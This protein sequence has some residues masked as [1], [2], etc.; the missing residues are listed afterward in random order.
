MGVQDDHDCN[1][2]H[3]VDLEMWKYGLRVMSWQGK[4]RGN[5]G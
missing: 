5:E 4:I 1:F 2:F 3:W